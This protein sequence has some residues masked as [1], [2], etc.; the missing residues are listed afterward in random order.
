MIKS[1]DRFLQ[2][3]TRKL[4]NLGF[5]CEVYTEQ[6]GETTDKVS[7]CAIGG[8]DDNYMI[9]FKDIHDSMGNRR[10]KFEIND[11]KLNKRVEEIMCEKERG[12]VL[13][14]DKPS[15]MVNIFYPKT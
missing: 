13:R 2:D 14:Y 8:S 6:S 10:I 4:N 1:N 12:C 9:I 11:R 5:H 7:D 15:R 3:V